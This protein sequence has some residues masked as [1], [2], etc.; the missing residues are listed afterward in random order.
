MTAELASGFAEPVRHAQQGFRA[1]LDALSRP[2][3]VTHVAADGPTAPGLGPASTTLMLSLA[4]FETPVWLGAGAA[5][6]GEYFRFHC[7]C[8]ITRER[9]G[10]VIACLANPA[11]ALPL[12]DFELGSDKAP[13]ASAT[14]IIQVA[15]LD[16]QGSFEFSGP[17]IDGVHRIGIQGLPTE[18]LRER[19]MLA[20]LFPR[21]VD[22]FL[23]SGN[24][25]CGLPRTTTIK[26][27]PC[28]SR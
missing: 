1:A 8:P 17:G 11:E 25:L 2:G 18:W 21:G 3:R 26:E 14:L 24:R 22:I 6:S 10:A 28:M 20:P 13:E 23:T 19:A 7:G 4:D 15:A 9:G 27:T 16:D 5:A 12:A